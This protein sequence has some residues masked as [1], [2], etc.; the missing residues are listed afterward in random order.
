MLVADM[1]SNLD[2]TKQSMES[3]KVTEEPHF[4]SKSYTL[5]ISCSLGAAQVLFCYYM[6]EETIKYMVYF[7]CGFLIINIFIY[8]LKNQKFRNLQFIC[9]IQYTANLLLANL[10]LEYSLNKTAILIG[11]GATIL[12]LNMLEIY[13]PEHLYL[14]FIAFN[15]L[16]MY[17]L[18]KY[19]TFKETN[20]KFLMFFA[21]FLV[22]AALVLPF[23]YKKMEV[24]IFISR[25]INLY[26]I[27]SLFVD[28]YICEMS[29]LLNKSDPFLPILNFMI[30]GICFLLSVFQVPRNDIKLSKYIYNHMPK[31]FINKEIKENTYEQTPSIVYIEEEK[32]NETVED[33]IEKLDNIK[34]EKGEIEPE[35]DFID[36]NTPV[37]IKKNA[38]TP[39]EIPKPSEYN[40]DKFDGFKHS[41]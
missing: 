7:N 22:N 24:S 8:L 18:S 5:G 2:P 23:I 17:Q 33:K 19:L 40:P 25:I 34:K 11:M 41:Y 3:K 35:K 20:F 37:N 1:I 39:I 15:T 30:L 14:V 29:T 28:T 9:S 21:L 38:A 6:L 4:L 16:A 26:L 36:K 13:L 31:E 10:C 27:F 12:A 32:E